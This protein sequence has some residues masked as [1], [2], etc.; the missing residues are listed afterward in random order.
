[1]DGDAVSAPAAFSST[2]TSNRTSCVT[3]EPGCLRRRR[4]EEGAFQYR[5][6]SSGPRSKRGNYS[7]PLERRNEGMTTKSGLQSRQQRQTLFAQGGQIASN[8]A[9]GLGTSEGAETAGNLLLHFD[10]A[11]IP[12]GQ[13][14]VKIDTKIL[15][16]AEDRFLVLAQP[17]KQIAGR[18]LFA[19]T[20]CSRWG[21]STRMGQITF[22]INADV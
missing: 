15:Q 20:S 10:H 6:H 19:S 3:F 7:G 1:M 4:A 18:T 2:G 22:V 11:Q 9:K 13:I 14:V 5:R 17:I 8:A 12:F 21:L 16:E